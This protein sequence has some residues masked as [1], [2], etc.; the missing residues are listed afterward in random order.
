VVHVSASQMF[1]GPVHAADWG[2]SIVPHAKF[3]GGKQT[4][5]RLVCCNLSHR[6]IHREVGDFKCHFPAVQ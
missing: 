6:D 5:E 2:P 4:S 3:A 1:V